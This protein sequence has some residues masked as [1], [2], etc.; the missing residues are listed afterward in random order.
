MTGAPVAVLKDIS[1]SG[2]ES[3]II[4]YSGAGQLAWS[5]GLVRYS[6]MEEI[7][8]VRISS[9]GD[10][11]PLPVAHDQYG[12]G[13]RVSPDGGRLVVSDEWGGPWLVELDLG[14]RSRIVQEEGYEFPAWT[15][16]GRAVAF[17]RLGAPFDFMLVEPRSGATPRRVASISEEAHVDDVTPDGHDLT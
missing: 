9:A 2:N 17:I 16:D 11:T 6:G 15:P 4:A 13:I 5:T 12:R 7:R 1:R 3:A 8:L 14:R 10:V